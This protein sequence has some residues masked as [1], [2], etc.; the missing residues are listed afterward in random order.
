MSSDDMVASPSFESVG[1][2]EKHA[3]ARRVGLSTR[4]GFAEDVNRVA[5]STILAEGMVIFMDPVTH[6]P[7]KAVPVGRSIRRLI[8]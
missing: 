8:I 1:S 5:I 3:G 6:L 7:L 2:R 4:T